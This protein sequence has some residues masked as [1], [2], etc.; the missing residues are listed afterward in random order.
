[1]SMLDQKPYF[2]QATYDWIVDSEKTP[3]IL[4][5]TNVFGVQVPEDQIDDHRIVLN[6]GPEATR[7][8][9]IDRHRLTCLITVSGAICEIVV[10]M[11]ALLSIYAAE[12]GQGLH[13]EPL[14]ESDWAEEAGEIES[15]SGEHPEKKLPDGKPHL[16]VVD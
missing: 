15:T 7:S 1:M 10:P 6:V 14:G 4:V 5:Q 9:Q 12:N 13:F 11:P 8:F 2:V 3:H 16:T